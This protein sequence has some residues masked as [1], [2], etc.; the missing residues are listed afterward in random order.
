VSTKTVPALS[1]LGEPVPPSNPVT[2]A[3]GTISVDPAVRIM[4]RSVVT[5]IP[6]RS[7]TQAHAAMAATSAAPGMSSAQRTGWR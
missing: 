3:H 5:P 2:C 7:G 4:T 1:L 6:A